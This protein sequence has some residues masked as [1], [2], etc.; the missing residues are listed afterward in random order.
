MALRP[1]QLDARLQLPGPW[2]Q[3]EFEP[4][5]LACT[6]FALPYRDTNPG[7]NRSTAS[8]ISPSM[9]ISVNLATASGSFTV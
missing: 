2:R 8:V 5:S 3:F 9:P 1:C 7:A 4:P 6:R